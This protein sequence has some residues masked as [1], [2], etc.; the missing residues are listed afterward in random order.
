MAKLLFVRQR[1][2]CLG[3]VFIGRKLRMTKREPTKRGERSPRDASERAPSP[4][5]AAISAY[6]ETFNPMIRSIVFG[7]LLY[8]SSAWADTFRVHYSIRGS[9]RDVT[10]QAES[11]AEARRTVMDMFNGAAVTGVSRIKR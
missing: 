3:S 4:Q 7:F 2:L 8:S 11:S 5:T 10:V 1:F 9:G 6:T